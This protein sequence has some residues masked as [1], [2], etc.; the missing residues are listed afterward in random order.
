M[1][2]ILLGTP[3]GGKGTQAKLI[4]D[5]LK[6]PHISTGDIFRSKVKDG[7]ALAL[8]IED[9]TQKGKLVPDYITISLIED[10]LKKEDCANGF[11]L[12]GFPRNENQAEALD[13]ILNKQNEHIDRVFLIDVP[14]AAILDRLAGRRVCPKCGESYHIKYNPPK[15]EGKCDICGTDLVHRSDDQEEIILDRLAIYKETTKPILDF[16][17]EKG[18]LHKIKGDDGIN[19]IFNRIRKIL[20]ADG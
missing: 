11:L 16:Y 7:D 13:L 4:C 10:R 14:E 3:G 9:Y 18:I 19:D 20:D 1:K 8:E 5:Y 17:N 15:I 6:I 12:D 2:I